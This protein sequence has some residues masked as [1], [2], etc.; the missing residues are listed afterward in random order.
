MGRACGCHCV[1]DSDAE[2]WYGS[3]TDNLTGE[4]GR[5][6]LRATGTVGKYERSHYDFT[7]S[8]SGERRAGET[9]KCRVVVGRADFLDVIVPDTMPEPRVG[10]E[11]DWA[12]VPE[13]RGGRLRLKVAGDFLEQVGAVI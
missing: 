10:D 7:D 2:G 8:T 1:G 9:R 11:I 12:I 3:L 13:V 6:M 5:H 4:A